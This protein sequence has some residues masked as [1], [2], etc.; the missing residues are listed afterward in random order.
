M[1]QVDPLGLV[2]FGPAI[3]LEFRILQDIY[4]TPYYRYYYAGL[5]YHARYTDFWRS[6]NIKVI[7]ASMG[8]GVS[9]KSLIGKI[10][11]RS[12]YF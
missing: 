12:R 10:Q 11:Q 3:S 1:W 4:I 8:F 7:P 9:V 2:E 5:L 6:A